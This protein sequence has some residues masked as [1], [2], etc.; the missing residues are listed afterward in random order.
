VLSGPMGVYLK[1]GVAICQCYPPNFPN[2]FYLGQLKSSI[3]LPP[4]NTCPTRIIIMDMNDPFGHQV[5][6]ARPIQLL[7]SHRFPTRPKWTTPSRQVPDISGRHYV[8]NSGNL[9]LQVFPLLARSSIAS[10]SASPGPLQ[11]P[12]KYY[13]L[14]FPV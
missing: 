8:P 12:V 11:H 2:R 3:E 1:R 10:H 5:S 9:R 6:T 4:I 14:D 7:L 13:C